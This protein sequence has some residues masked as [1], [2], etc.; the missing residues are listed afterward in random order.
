MIHTHTSVAEKNIFQI[1]TIRLNA[2][3][4]ITLMLYA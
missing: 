4:L 2:Q 3:P 1:S